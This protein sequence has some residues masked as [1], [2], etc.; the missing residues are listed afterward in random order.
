MFV[1]SIANQQST[2]PKLLADFFLFLLL[3]RALLAVSPSCKSDSPKTTCSSLYATLGLSAAGCSSILQCTDMKV[4]FVLSSTLGK[5]KTL[6]KM[7]NYPFIVAHDMSQESAAGKKVGIFALLVPLS[8][9]L[10]F[11]FCLFFLWVLGQLPEIRTVV[12][13]SLR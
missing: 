7:L 12:D 3:D 4:G 2:N 5:A 9:S 11:F 6:L 13:T 8:G 10:L 1:K